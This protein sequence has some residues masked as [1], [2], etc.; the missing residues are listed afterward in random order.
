MAVAVVIVE[1]ACGRA[2][3]GAEGRGGKQRTLSSLPKASASSEPVAAQFLSLGVGAAM[4]CHD[5]SA[6]A[7]W[8]RPS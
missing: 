5:F 2:R 8:W 4:S 7:T 3:G 1:V 6:A